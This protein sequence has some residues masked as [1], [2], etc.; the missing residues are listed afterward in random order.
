MPAV[1]GDVFGLG[2]VFLRQSTP[3]TVGSIG[4]GTVGISTNTFTQVFV[5]GWSDLRSYGWFGGGRNPGQG[6][7][8]AD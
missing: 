3:I 2:D 8:S 4:V 5:S 7:D 6:R 1:V